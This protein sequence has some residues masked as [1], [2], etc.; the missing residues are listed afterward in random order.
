[1][2]A[3]IDPTIYR[4][5]A[6]AF[7]K[8]RSY[9]LTEDALTWEEDGGKLD[10]VFYDGIAEVRLAFA[11]TRV[12]PNR[13][14]TQIVFHRGGMAELFNLD[15]V[16]FATFAAHDAEYIAF[17]TELHR[18]LAVHGKDVVYRRGNSVGA[19]V[20]NVALT[21]FILVTI[22]VA[23]LLLFTW[24]GPLVAIAKLAILLFFV[25]VLV[26]YIRR[27]RPGTYDPLALP[28]DV[29]PAAGDRGEEKPDG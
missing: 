16:S 4:L 20:F 18:R 7:V 2:S 17:V 15:Y 24:G 27:A 25:P 6:N 11:P 9:R 8:P 13:Y 1:M 19:F 5:R 26:R 14:R 22:V 3:A 21:I 28:A 12:A 23:F 10:G 29:L